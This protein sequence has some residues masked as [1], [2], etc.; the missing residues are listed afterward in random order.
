ML[1]LV[2]RTRDEK[3]TEERA[4]NRLSRRCL[5][6]L[7]PGITRP[8]YDIAR[9]RT[10]IV[11]LGLGAFHRAHQAV[12]T[13]SALEGGDLRWGIAGV[14][15]RSPAVGEALVPQEG[16]YSVSERDGA[17]VRTRVIGAVREVLHAPSALPNVLS[18]IASPDVHVVTITV[19]EKGYSQHPA[20]GDLDVA[21]SGI[22]HDLSHPDSPQTTLGVLGAGIARRPANAPLTILCCDNMA[23]N[24]PTVQRLLSQYASRVD[25]QLVSR[26]ESHIA[27]PSSMVDRIVPAATPESLSWAEQR[28]GLRDDAAIV[29]EPFTQWVIEDRFAGARPAWERAGALLTTDV[30]PFQAM[31][32]RLLNGVHS[33]IAYVGQL[34]G[35]PTVSEAMAD[36]LV[37]AFARRL[38]KDDLLATVSAPPGFDVRAYCDALL[39]R[40]ENPNLAHRTEQIAMDGTQKVPVRWLPPLRESLRDAVER[41]E[42]ERARA[43][44]LH[45]LAAAVNEAGEALKIHDAG[46]AELASR[47]RAGASESESIRSAFSH[48]SVFGDTEWPQA[49]VDRMANHL[50]TL[51]G[52]G[53]AALIR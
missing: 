4:V 42:L 36:P 11:H 9:V 40:F 35:L 21:D 46:A 1:P 13:E 23:N 34:R 2:K 18:A 52:G 48:T 7:G 28:L 30:R 43:C 24:G 44:W 37:G 29:C 16:L 31:K 50:K 33:A 8:G 10:G 41:K 14:S 53:V 49:F 6:A 25:P 26:I 22:E 27:F 15:L 39:Q 20:S 12:Y 32:L 38:M 3:T 45:Y 47:L 51:R 19:T 5:S 17:Q